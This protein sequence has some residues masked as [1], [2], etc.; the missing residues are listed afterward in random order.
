MPAACSDTPNICETRQADFAARVGTTYKSMFVA[1]NPYD[2]RRGFEAKPGTCDDT[3][4][5]ACGCNAG[6]AQKSSDPSTC[7]D[8]LECDS[9]PCVAS[10]LLT[11]QCR[12]VWG[13]HECVCQTHA[14]H[15]SNDLTTCRRR[16]L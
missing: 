14:E 12:E 1:A 2:G 13:S 5:L 3:S 15:P 4:V 7:E 8:V 16:C 10:V 9:S 6:F 11:G